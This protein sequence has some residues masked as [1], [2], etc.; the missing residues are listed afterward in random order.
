MIH[1]PVLRRGEPYRSLSTLPLRDLRDG[2]QIGE[3]GL[4]N[5]GLIARDL[6][7]TADT[8]RDLQDSIPCSELMA[9]CRR[10]ADIFLHQPLPAGDAVHGPEEYLR[11]LAATTGMP[12]AMGR[13][14][15]QKIAFVLR[16][17]ERVVAG[18][19]RDLPL[20]TIDRGWSETDGRMLSFRRTTDVLGAVLPSNSPGVHS[21]WL[22]AIALKIPLALKPGRQEPWTPL[23]IGQ[24]LLAAGVPPAMIGIY[25]TD[26]GGAA[27]LLQRCG[28]SLLFGDRSTVASWAS[29]P[30]VQLH[31]PGWSKVLFGAD[32]ASTASDHLDL[33]VDS[34]AANGGRSCINASGVWMPS[35]GRQFGLELAERLASITA[36]PLDHPEARL[37]AAPSRDA[38]EAQSAF[39]DARIAKAGGEDLTARFRP[40]GRV[41][42]VDG[43]A[44][45]LP[46]V[47]YTDDPT[48]NLAQTELLFPLV[49]VVEAP[50]ETLLENLGPTLVLSL[51]SDDPDLKRQIATDRRVDRLNLG[52]LPTTQVS[53][54]QPHEGNLFHHLYEQRALQRSAP[55]PVE[56]PE[57]EV[58]SQGGNAA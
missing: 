49:T 52:A 25:P 27:E 1:L 18:L 38:A 12:M 9:I 31:G 51:I 23:R 33:V 17:M 26:H 54:D 57:G 55:S 29:D 22:P 44:F 21:L 19:T 20:A 5:P 24:A 3:L 28:R 30:R 42:E 11:H 7:L 47:L 34:V 53:W 15:M 35:H 4:A 37:A 6:A 56:A 13:R 45:L 16:E 58:E 10:A 41:A 36:S 2:R 14:N 48:A 40:E 32:T 50:Q 43:C 8:A 46:T 39:V